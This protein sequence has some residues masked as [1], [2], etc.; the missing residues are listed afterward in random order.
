MYNL[1]KGRRNWYTSDLTSGIKETERDRFFKGMVEFV[2]QHASVHK[3][4]LQDVEIPASH[5]LYR[6]G[7]H[8]IPSVYYAIQSLLPSFQN[9]RSLTTGCIKLLARSTDTSCLESMT[10]LRHNGDLQKEEVSELLKKHPPFLPRHRSLKHLTT[11]TLGP[12]M[13][14]WAVLEKKKQTD[15]EHQQESIV[16]RHLISG[17]HGRHTN[18]LV[19]LQSISISNLKPYVMDQEL[20]DIAFAFSDSLEEWT[21][22]DG[23]K[24][25][26]EPE[27]EEE[28]EED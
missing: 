11:E 3:N 13:F 7:Q 27:E 24:R 23:Y 5:Q 4:V 18:D 2:R 9:L 10:V 8:S 20:N 19:S 14:Q 21:V 28:E 22:E 26:E 25:Y 17:Q 15:A 12:D 16:D 1:R 6:T